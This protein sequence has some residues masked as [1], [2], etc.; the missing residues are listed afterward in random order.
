MKS[1]LDTEKRGITFTHVNRL[2]TSNSMGVP[3]LFSD[4]EGVSRKIKQAELMANGYN[5]DMSNDT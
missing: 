2:E 5:G 1:S 3:R 4:D